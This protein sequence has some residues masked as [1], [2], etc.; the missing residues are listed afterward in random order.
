MDKNYLEKKF[1]QILLNT[2]HIR[3][4]MLHIWPILV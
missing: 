1:H 2:I 3:L 4:S